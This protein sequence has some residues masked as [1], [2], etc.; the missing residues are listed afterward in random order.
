V[1]I[2]GVARLVWVVRMWWVPIEIGYMPVITADRAGAQTPAVEK[3]FSQMQPSPA[4]RS[5]RGV[6]ATSSP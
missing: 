5:S 6:R 2:L 3:A 4:S 1:G